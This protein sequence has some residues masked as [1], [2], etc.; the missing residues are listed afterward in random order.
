[1]LGAGVAI[2]LGA[3][4]PRDPRGV[5]GFWLLIVLMAAVYAGAAFGP[6]PPTVQAVVYA[7]FAQFLFVV[8]AAWAVKYRTPR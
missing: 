4:R 3:T 7:G 2:Y 1:M 8:L 6:R 5:W